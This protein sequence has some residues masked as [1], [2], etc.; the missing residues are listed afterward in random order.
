MPSLR[1]LTDSRAEEVGGRR[2]FRN[3]RVTASEIFAATARRTGSAA[4]GLHVLVIEDT[5][6]INYQAKAGRKRGLGR[7]GNGVDC[8]LF[9]HSALAVEAGSGL[10]L[11]LA[12]GVIWNRTAAKAANYQEL[13]IEDKESWRWIEAFHQALGQLGAAARVT[14]V[15]DREGD[16]YELLARVS[17]QADLIVRA[18]HDRAVN[19]AQKRLFARLADQAVAETILLRVPARDGRAERE[20]KLELRFCPVRLRRPRRGF[21]PRDPDEVA[22]SCIEVREVDAPAQVEEPLLW[23]LYTTHAVTTPEEAR[24][25]IGFYRQRWTIEQLHRTM[26]SRGLDIEES[27][28]ADAHALENYAAAVVTASVRVM[29]LVQ[30]R[31]AAGE[32]VSAERVF[33]AEEIQV[34]EAVVPKFE[35]RTEKQKNPHPLH[36]LAW[37]AWLIARLGGWKGYASERPPGPETFTRGLTRFNAIAEGFAFARQSLHNKP[38]GSTKQTQ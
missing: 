18:T 10:L 33:D 8:G 2:F 19:D 11:G 16:I 31:G 22:L 28:L 20:V 37:A 35:G 26:K 9:V 38:Y 36:S 13:P 6:E 24:T 21:D 34:L 25:V 14:L 17:A 7:V 3:E 15:T 23:R 1:G 4:C 30:A 29:Q 5:T 32:V 12:G 27:L